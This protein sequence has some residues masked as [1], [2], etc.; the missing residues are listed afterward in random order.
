[1]KSKNIKLRINEL[2]ISKLL[3]SKDNNLVKLN[4]IYKVL[5]NLSNILKSM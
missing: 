1:M 2:N 4:L 5:L 3:S